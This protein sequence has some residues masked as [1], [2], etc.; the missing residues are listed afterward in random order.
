[1]RIDLACAAATLL[2]GVLLTA[3]PVQAA[4]PMGCNEAQ[5]T[6]MRQVAFDVC[7]VSGGTTYAYCNG[8]NVSIVSVVCA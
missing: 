1:M 4:R 2:G 5:K 6:Y 8:M 3:E 7:G